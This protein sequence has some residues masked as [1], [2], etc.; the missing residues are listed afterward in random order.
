M[1]ELDEFGN[2]MAIANGVNSHG[3]G[4]S[5]SLKRV[6]VGKMAPAM[7]SASYYLYNKNFVQYSVHK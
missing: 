7:P 1:F 2:G 4:K 5:I 3:N 6:L